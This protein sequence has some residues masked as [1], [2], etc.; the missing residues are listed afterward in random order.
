MTVKTF[1]DRPILSGVISVAIIIV[2]LIGLSQLPVEQFP[3]IAP[4]TVRVSA[5]YTGANAET[6]MKSV[7]TPLE[8][9]LNGVENMM[10]MTSTATNTGSAS[11]SVYF[12][13]GTDPDMSVVNVQNRVASAQGLLPAEVT[14]SGITVRKRQ[15]NSLKALSLYSPDDSYDANFLTNYMKINIEPRLSRIAGVGDVNI[16]GASY[17][18]RIWLDPLQMAQYG[19]MPSDIATVLGEQNV[20]SPT[21]T[22]GSESANTFQYVLKYRGRYEDETDYENMVIRSLPN[23]EVLRLKD[24]AR[25]ELGAENY[26]MLSQTSGHPGANCMMAQT[27]GSNANEIIKEIDDVTAD[28]S[29]SLP[30]GMILTDITSTKD[31]LDASIANV[32]ETLFVAIVLVVLVVYLFLH[33]LRATLIPS[34]A[35]IVSLVGTF[36]FIY[37]VGFSLNLLTLFALVLVIGTVVDDSIVVVEAVQAR[38]DE[39]YTTAYHA[40]VDAM[41][42]LTSAL[43]TT[44]IVFMAVFIP[45]SFMG[46]T[47]GVFY[48][49][50]GLT[51]AVAVAISLLNAMTL[52]PALCALIMRPRV[53]MENDGK[54]GFSDRFHYAF[55]RSFRHVQQKYMRGVSFL[56]R[57]KGIA[58][59]SI[60]VACVA[61]VVLMHTTKTGLVPQ[62]DM[63][64]I[65]VN[66]QTAPGS[67]LEETERIMDEIEAA[68]HDIPQIKIYSRVTGKDARHNQ[69]ASAGSFTIRLKNWS[70]RTKEGDDVNSVMKEIYHRTDAIKAAQIRV[71]TSPMISGYGMS[72]GF[73]LYV[74]DKK[75]SSMEDLLTYTRAFIDAMNRRPEISRAYTTF[76]TKYPQFIVEVDAALCKRNGISP[77]DVLS[78]LSGYIGG[79]YSS[80]LNRF[81]KL[82]RVMVQASPEYRLDTE[83]LNNIYVRNANGEMSP[84]TQYLTLTRVYGSE[85]LSRFN[86]FSAITVYGAPADGYSSGQAIKAIEEVARTSL[87]EGYGYEFGGMTRE[88]AATGNTTTLVFIVCIV[89][90]YLILCALYE[91]LLIPFA[92]IL[93]VPFGLM[94]S[95]LFAKLWGLENNIYMQTGLIM[96]I[97]LLSKTAILLTEYASDRRHQGMSIT[98]AAM[99][100]AKARLRPILMTS[101]TMVFGMLPLMFAQGVGANGNISVGVGT[102]GGMLL[103]T[104]ALLFVVPSLFIL[105]QYIQERFL[106][107][108]KEL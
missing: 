39:G 94:G 71:S 46:G 107:G 48:T 100:A 27:S 68:I 50:F 74:Q 95:F 66:V 87:P 20:E 14:K 89:F 34:L 69:S 31:F 42:G 12:R 2:G 76:D 8:E 90:I 17:S 88:E 78:T 47:T 35:I 92:V 41:S 37:V 70:E 16:W 4:P 7:I 91:S 57:H 101:L 58:V 15:S 72:D 62:E 67:N 80:N 51:M 97:G 45:V 82:Y 65:N 60:M 44:T 40:T 55:D 81:T 53:S 11:I 108:R 99:S 29:A 13:Q 1:I 25:I 18:L 103:G 10:Y 104:V 84:V 106:P 86:L 26:A 64:T 93:S 43:I 19:L 52:S 23:G 3:D 73:E 6:V 79:S 49:Q 56:F 54:P 59:G 75:G 61:L 105:C 83:A 22:L 102:V 63:G 5:T 77:T 32:V 28:I 33:D 38:F 96:L 98:T 24:V 85:S 36:A 30:K 21:G 9:Q